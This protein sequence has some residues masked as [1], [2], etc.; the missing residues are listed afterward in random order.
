MERMKFLRRRARPEWARLPIL[1]QEYPE[2]D[3]K[4]EGAVTAAFGQQGYDDGRKDEEASGD[5]EADQ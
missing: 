1:Q 2:A 3:C 5:P 4:C